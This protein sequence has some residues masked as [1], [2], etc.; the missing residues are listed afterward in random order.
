MKTQFVPYDIAKELKELGF[1]ELC[2]YAYDEV[3]MI[4]TVGLTPFDP[5]NY[6]SKSGGGYIS[7][8]LWQQVFDWLYEKHGI[9][10]E[11][12]INLH[13]GSERDNLKPGK[14]IY[15]Y[16]IYQIKPDGKAYGSLM[17]D[18]FNWSPNEMQ[19]SIIRKTLKKIKPLET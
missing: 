17:V 18:G 3:P 16:R 9:F 12:F 4:C 2:V 14:I 15:S 1:K 19:E 11:Q 5:L 10:V 8:P 13:P 7:A 6:N